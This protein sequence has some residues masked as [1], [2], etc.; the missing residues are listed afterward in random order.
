MPGAGIEP[1]HSSAARDFKSL[2]STIS[3]TQ[4]RS[5]IETVPLTV[6]VIIYQIV[7]GVSIGA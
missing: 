4:A 1:A 2:A 3:A 7:Y 5:R 6:R